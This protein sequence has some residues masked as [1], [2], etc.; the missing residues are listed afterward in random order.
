MGT[1]AELTCVEEGKG[2]DGIKVKVSL[3]VGLE[4]AVSSDGSFR[5]RF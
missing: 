2:R 3:R 5:S 1:R 4:Q